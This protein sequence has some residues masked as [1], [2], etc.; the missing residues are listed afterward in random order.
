LTQSP[1]LVGPPGRLRTTWRVAAFVGVSIVAVVVAQQIVYFVASPL[2]TATG[3]RYDLSN[4]M[5][6]VAL[7]ASTGVVLRWID[8]A[9]WSLVRLGRD[10][11][12]PARSANGLLAGA[13]AMVIP[14]G[15]LLSVGWLQI[16]PWPGDDRLSTGIRL[17]MML[18]PAALWEELAFRGYLFS[19]LEQGGGRVFAVVSTSLLFGVAHAQ[20]PG[21]NVQPIILVTLAG[22]FLSLVVLATQ[23]LY[24]AWLA[25]FSFNWTQAV[26]FHAPVSGGAFATPGYRLVDAGPDWATGGPWGP[27]GGFTAI[28]GLTAAASYLYWRR[29]RREER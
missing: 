6:C 21:A 29:S 5:L 4:V 10:A 15:V 11:A 24:A 12:H 7:V 14:T 27:E 19:A 17:T 22:V 16:V 13:I 23:S 1:V 8:H 18:L 25:H 20:N 9:P 26:A 28:L 2:V 3:A